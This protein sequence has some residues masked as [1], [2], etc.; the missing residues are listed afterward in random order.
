MAE[1]I[2]AGLRPYRQS[3]RLLAHRGGLYRAAGRVDIVDD[4]VEP[5]GQP[6]L[7]SVDA[8]IAHIGAAAAGDRPDMLDLASREVENRDATLAVRRPA[9]RVRAAVRDIE[10][11]AVAARVEPVRSDPGRDEIGLDEAVAVHDIHAVGVHIG[12]IEV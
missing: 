2:A 6:E 11:L 3:M 9:R 7:L 12:H 4:I 5:P 10:L 1:G 8:D